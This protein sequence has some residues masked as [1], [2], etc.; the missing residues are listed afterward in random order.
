[1]RY[2][3]LKQ[4]YLKPKS[5]SPLEFLREMVENGWHTLLSNL[6]IAL[7]IFLSLPVSI[8]EGERK[9]RGLKRLKDDKKK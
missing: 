2:F 4:C 1:M 8:T 6:V 3:L 7:R 9:F 5:K